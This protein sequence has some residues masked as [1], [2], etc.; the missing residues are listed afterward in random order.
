VCVLANRIIWCAAIIWGLSAAT[1]TLAAPPAP[2]ISSVIPNSGPITGGTGVTITGTNLT[3]ATAVTFGGTAATGVTVA[4]ATTITATTP[5]HAAGAV[6]VVVTNSSGIGT[7]TGAYTYVATPTVTSVIPNSGPITGGT[8]VTITGTNLTG[9]TAVTF[10]GTAA[11]GVT[12]VNATTI[13][14]TTPAHAA[15]AVDVVVTTPG[16]I[17]TGTGAYTY[18]ATPTVT[19]T[20]IT[21]SVNPS[22]VGQS[23]TFTGTVE[24]GGGTATGT[25]TFKDG[26]TTLG[27]MP[28]S[29]NKAIFTTASLTLGIHSIVAVYAG[30]AIYAASTS[31]VLRQSVAVPADSLKLRALQIAITKIEALSSGHAISGAIDGAISEGFSENDAL[32]TAS[33]NGVHFNFSGASQEHK[34]KVDEHVGDAFAAL[35]FARDNPKHN[36]PPQH[37]EPKEWL[38]WADV[39][40]T[41]WN[42]N[43]QVGDIR[44]GQ[45]NALLGLTRKLKPTLLFG[46]FGGYEY[47]DYT[48]ELLSGRLKGDGWTVGGYLGWRILPTLRLDAGISR[49]WV[50]YNGAAG[51]AA[52]TF[53]AQRWLATAALIGT[54]ETMYGFQIEPSAKVYVLWEHDNSYTDSLGT[55]Q[56][57]RNFSTGRASTGAKLVYPWL[58]S[59]TKVAP[60]VGVYADYYFNYDDATLPVAPLLIPTEFVDGWSARATLGINATIPNGTSLSVGGEVGGL[61]SGNFTV[62]SVRGRVSVPF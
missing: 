33:D 8:G 19:T 24:T 12:V 10:G 57:E 31:A 4:N 5:A 26:T 58:W 36:A 13:T 42:T 7:G 3:G 37:I 1:L 38:A 48:S 9:A 51:T 45:T 15:G 2:T 35:G 49:S 54:Y 40:G 52:A 59:T 43:M 56:S 60:Y 14:A 29:V 28:V 16:G 41:G 27:T 61:G 47:F 6:D 17:G 44:G 62:W 18:V 23:V 50:S 22:N 34:S 20:S 32:I 11:T 53:P 21:S 39:R 30:D 55:L 25:V 46:V